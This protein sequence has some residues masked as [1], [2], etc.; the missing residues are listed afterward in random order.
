MPASTASG[1]AAATAISSSCGEPGV[2]VGVSVVSDA[3]ALL[4]DDGLPEGAA[5]PAP[6]VSDGEA[7]PL[8]A[9]ASEERGS[10][11]EHEVSI[12]AMAVRPTVVLR[13][14]RCMGPLER[15]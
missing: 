2:V 9:G 13:E 4:S 11:V 6:E 3:E 7:V 14:G 1:C 10:G 12:S 15:A 5:V 8:C